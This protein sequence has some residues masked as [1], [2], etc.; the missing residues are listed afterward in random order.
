MEYSEIENIW[1]EEIKKMIPQDYQIVV[2]PLR[3]TYTDYMRIKA[4]V[5]EN[6]EGI[7][8]KGKKLV[9]GIACKIFNY[10]NKINSVR[11]LIY[12]FT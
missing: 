6:L 3:F 2:V 4:V 12:N 5:I 10:P 8:S 9:F 7:Y 11:V 1:E